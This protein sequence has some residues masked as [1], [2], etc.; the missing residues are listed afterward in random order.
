MSLELTK[1]NYSLSLCIVNK[2]VALKYMINENEIYKIVGENLASARK[3]RLKITQSDMA[4]RLNL[5]RTSISNIERGKQKAPLSL[6]YM[7]CLEVDKEIT[8]ILPNLRDLSQD[9]NVSGRVPRVSNIQ[10]VLPNSIADLIE[11]I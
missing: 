2:K 11:S 4:K 8:D 7:Y 1:F 3:S 10:G 6:I 5:T 9:G